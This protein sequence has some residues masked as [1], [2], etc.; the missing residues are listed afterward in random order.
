MNTESRTLRHRF[1]TLFVTSLAVAGCSFFSMRIL[2]RPYADLAVLL[3]FSLTALW[4]VLLRVAVVRYR[5]QGLWVLI[6]APLALFYPTLFILWMLECFHN[7]AA[8]P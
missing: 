3:T 5:K 4:A 1:T 7:A 2:F 8:C 6:G